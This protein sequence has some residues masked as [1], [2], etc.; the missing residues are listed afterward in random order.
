MQQVLTIKL[1]ILP[2]EAG[3]K[4]LQPIQGPA[5]LLR[6]GSLKTTFP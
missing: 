6:K 5:L 2:D 4:L 3:K 1:K